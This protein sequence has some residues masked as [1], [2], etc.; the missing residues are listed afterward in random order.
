MKVN[1]TTGL[2][3][4]NLADNNQYP[5]TANNKSLSELF[6]DAQIGERSPVY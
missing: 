6:G 2:L 4:S 3:S 1:Q 5:M